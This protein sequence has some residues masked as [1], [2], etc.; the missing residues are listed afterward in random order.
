MSKAFTRESEGDDGDDDLERPLGTE[1]PPGVKN[2]LTPRGAARL[3][4]ELERFSQVERPALAA[5]GDARTLREI[6]RR[7]TFLDR[8]LE[9]MEIVDPTSQPSDRVLFGAT[10]TVRDEDG[11]E[12]SYRL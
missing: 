12:R 8:R 4:A 10:V 3:R 6:E 1:L 9:A 7:I 11:T 2:Y 5:A